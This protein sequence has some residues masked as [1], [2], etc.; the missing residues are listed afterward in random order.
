MRD[1]L[2]FDKRLIERHIA[3]GLLEK[4]ALDAFISELPDV[5]GRAAPLRAALD[6][7]GVRNVARK[8][9][10]ETDD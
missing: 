1:A 5:G 9:V 4:T 8:D 10:G 7:V 2:K 3:L 6:A